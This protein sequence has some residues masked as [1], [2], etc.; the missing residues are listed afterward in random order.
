MFSLIPVLLCQ[1]A[2][3]SLIFRDTYPAFKRKPIF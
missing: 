1:R 3:C 2:P